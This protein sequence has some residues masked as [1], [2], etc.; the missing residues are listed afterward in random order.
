MK[1][2]NP[3][4]SIEA[5][6]SLDPE[7]LNETYKGIIKALN[8]L[9]TGTYEDIAAFLKK[10]RIAIGRRMKEVMDKGLVY[11]TGQTKQLKSG[12]KGFIWA[13]TNGSLIKTEIEAGNVFKK[14]VK[15]STDFA[16]DIIKSSF[17]EPKQG[18]LF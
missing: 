6:K 4:T 12:R 1:R 9:G 18:K 7:S 8:V 10:D 11:R 5:Y 17:K 3:D 13:L 15:S 14:K 2:K 16:N